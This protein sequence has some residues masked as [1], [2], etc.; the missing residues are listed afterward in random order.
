MPTNTFF[1]L[2]EEK[3]VRLI[4]AAWEEFTSTRFS[5]VSINRIIHHARIPR[6][7]FY[8][9]FEDKEDLFIYLM[10]DI[11]RHFV[12]ALEEMLIQAGGNLFDLPF[13]AFERFQQ[14]SME[15][16]PLLE[17]CTHIL[18]INPGLDCQN[19]LRKKPEN[20]PASLLACIDVSQLREQN[21]AF[22]E[23]TFVLLMAAVASIV[24]EA[25]ARPEDMEQQ[26]QLLRRRVEII[27]FGS[28]KQPAIK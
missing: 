19:L 16:D 8:Q 25:L 26:K 13:L 5:D 28:V 18:R 20:L 27:Q 21:A 4:D 9:Y 17:R 22:V 10:D 23:D 7:S 12:D 6:G 2:P 3:R 15:A 11:R 24:M 1:R 14:K